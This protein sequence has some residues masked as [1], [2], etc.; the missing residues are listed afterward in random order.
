M[1][2]NPKFTLVIPCRNEARSIFA[3]IEE[4]IKNL[5]LISDPISV[6]M[7]FVDDHS[8]D[9][10]LQV[11]LQASQKYKRL[12]V[13]NLE[14]TVEARALTHNYG[15]A[16]AQAFGLRL[17][18]SESDYLILMDADGQHNPKD[19][20]QIV[21]L[22]LTRPKTYVGKRTDYNRRIFER[23]L[24][25]GFSSISKLLGINYES[26]WSEFIGIP[27]SQACHLISLPELGI[28]PITSLVIM[29]YPET[30]F[31]ETKILARLD[32]TST[33][34]FNLKSLSRKA[35]MHLFCDPW[36]FF[37]RVFFL[38]ITTLFPVLGFTLY[39]GIHEFRAGNLSSTHVLLAISVLL[40]TI[41][42]IILNFVMGILLVFQKAALNQGKN[43]KL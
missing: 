24:T 23:I 22:L 38:S 34:R 17:A 1:T 43:V 35:L 11:I 26:E 41:Q 6:K 33:S 20:S 31:F 42:I 15:K 28:I 2:N 16:E 37:P 19:L 13:K 12:I 25:F 5:S 30:A 18:T 39:S 29:T 32:G 3:L 9:E 36:T 27:R 7:L 21:S 8:N 10:T 4:V 14:I 40:M